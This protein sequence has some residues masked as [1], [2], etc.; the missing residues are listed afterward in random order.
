VDEKHICL[1][2]IFSLLTFKTG[3]FIWAYLA[4]D[5]L[6]YV[7]AQLVAYTKYVYTH[8]HRFSNEPLT[9]II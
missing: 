8:L 2:Q 4:T 9:T 7:T 3:S 5:S 1:F 6:T